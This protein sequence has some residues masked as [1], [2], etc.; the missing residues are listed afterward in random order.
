MPAQAIGKHTRVWYEVDNW[1]FAQ[2]QSIRTG[3]WSEQGP[4]PSW[5]ADV[6]GVR[7]ELASWGILG[8]DGR[9][10]PLN[11][12]SWLWAAVSGLDGLTRKTVWMIK[13]IKGPDSSTVATSGQSTTRSPGLPDGAPP[14]N[15]PGDPLARLRYLVRKKGLR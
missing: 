11:D 12:G 10:A 9:W 13:I 5:M 1:I 15:H 3:P 8:W 7:G 6:P 4:M 2:A 14:A